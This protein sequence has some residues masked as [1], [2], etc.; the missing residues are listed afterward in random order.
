MSG[1]P[2][3]SASGLPGNRVLA[4]RAGMTA[5]TRKGVNESPV[6]WI[7]VSGGFL[8]S[9]RG[10]RR[11]RSGRGKQWIR[12]RRSGR[13]GLT[14]AQR[15]GC[16]L[17]WIV[18]WECKHARLGITDQAALSGQHAVRQRQQDVSA[19]PGIIMKVAVPRPASK[20]PLCEEDINDI[21]ALLLVEKCDVL[22][23]Q[24]AHR[25]TD[26]RTLHVRVRVQELQTAF[27]RGWQRR[28]SVLRATR[29]LLGRDHDWQQ[30]QRQESP[31]ELSRVMTDK[32][33]VQQ[34]SRF[35]WQIPRPLA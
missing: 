3:R 33:L 12:G 16:G 9:G 11:T 7:E 34:A 8:R 21:N 10:G 20:H 6:L 1:L 25:P 28:T 30:S 15:R 14:H 2:V 5:A 17:G 35:E 4:K 23:R 24:H 26:R 18:R 29:A 27:H 22:R 31:S 19:D 32:A 13:R